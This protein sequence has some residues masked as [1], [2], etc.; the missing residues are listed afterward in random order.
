RRIGSS[1][2]AV[3]TRQNSTLLYKSRQT[4]V[5]FLSRLDNHYCEE[6]EGNHGP[7][8]VEAYEASHINDTIPRKKKDPGSFTLPCYINNVCFDNA[9]I[10]LGASISV[11]PL[12]T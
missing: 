7:K 6:E 9:L 11:M 2:Y 1:Q 10:D 12:L 4:I 5:P 3:S 8:F